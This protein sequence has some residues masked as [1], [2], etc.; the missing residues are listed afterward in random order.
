MKRKTYYAIVLHFED[1]TEYSLNAVYD[2]GN[3]SDL[4]PWGFTR[5]AER[6]CIEYVNRSI[7]DLLRVEQRYFKE[8]EGT[9]D[10]KDLYIK[11]IFCDVNKYKTKLTGK[12]ELLNCP[13]EEEWQI[14]F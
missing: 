8:S 13:Y 2:T 3:L 6:H 12:L 7:H 9:Q 10:I 4:T 11:S 14:H 5:E 1:K